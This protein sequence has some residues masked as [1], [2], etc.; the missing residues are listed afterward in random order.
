VRRQ[1]GIFLTTALLASVA[2]ADPWLSDLSISTSLGWSDNIT[3]VA[4][5]QISETIAGLG[6]EATV[7]RQS[8][9]LN[10]NAA[11]DLQ[12]LEYLE[13][14]YDSEVTGSA[15]L[16]GR[17]TLVPDI[18]AFVVE[19]TFGQTQTD[20]LAPSTP[21]SRQGTNALSAGPDI[22][23]ELG[24]ALVL[25]GSGRYSLQSFEVT[26][27]DSTRL[28]GQA[29]LF[30]EFSADASIGVLA[31]SQNV[32]FASSSPYDDFKRTEAIGRF[33]LEASRTT[34]L[35]EGGRSKHDGEGVSG[36]QRQLWMYRAEATR[37]ITPRVSL[38]VGLGRELTDGGDLFQG[39]V[40]SSRRNS[41]FNQVGLG[42]TQLSGTNVLASGEGLQ[43][44]Y[45]RA[46]W[47]LLANRSRAI[48]GLE[49]RKE[50][51]FESVGLNRDISTL[52][53]GIG[54]TLS[55][56]LSMNLDLTFIKQSGEMSA[57][58]MEAYGASLT[59]TYRLSGP[60]STSFT[61]ERYQREDDNAGG[62]YS[63][64]RVWVRLVYAARR[65]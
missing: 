44:D 23:V 19:D 60:I 2:Q 16:T 36:A 58:R 41:E 37:D 43:S 55:S 29:G 65:N 5:N 49:H 30:H 9:T 3:G 7:E 26:P 56:A 32:S 54:R 50:R 48:I 21:E 51:N 59:G 14:T 63:D 46:N 18:L 8:R 11:I 28:Q 20:I 33:Q 12:F 45:W 47:R 34:L 31:S 17:A 35:V 39:A 15:E 13:G 62:G 40:G 1:G 6:V 38:I 22:R 27:A 52:Q 42:T 24:G 4:S 57:V 53:A 64:H 25:L 10:L 61:L